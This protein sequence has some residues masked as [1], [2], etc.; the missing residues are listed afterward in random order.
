MSPDPVRI[1]VPDVT[2]RYFDWFCTPD[3]EQA[4]AEYARKIMDEYYPVLTED[5]YVDQGYTVRI[6]RM[7]T[8]AKMLNIA[9]ILAEI[10]LYGFVKKCWNDKCFHSK[11]ALL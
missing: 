3:D 7:D 5:S 8:M 1:V 2:A 10:I 6:S 4:F 11:N 9:I